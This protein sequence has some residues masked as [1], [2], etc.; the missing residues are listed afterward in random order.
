MVHLYTS[1]SQS[2]T[3]R[4]K[5]ALS[6]ANFLQKLLTFAVSAIIA[7]TFQGYLDETHWD[8]CNLNNH[9]KTNMQTQL[10]DTCMMNVF[11]MGASN[12]V[13]LIMLA[14]V[15]STSTLILTFTVAFSPVEI[16]PSQ[17]PGPQYVK[18]K[19]K[20]SVEGCNKEYG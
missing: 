9:R 16:A 5:L 1:L 15:Y 11:M 7:F 19:Y 20:T 14:G 18:A 12:L 2:L 13:F 8:C 4:L 3:K 6:A 10:L 17:W